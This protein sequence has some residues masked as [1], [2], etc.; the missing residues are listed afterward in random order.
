MHPCSKYGSHAP[1]SAEA[2]TQASERSSDDADKAGSEE[3]AK[4][5]SA[6]DQSLLDAVKGVGEA[7]DFGG[8]KK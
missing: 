3:Q 2:T 1:A 8:G 4:S 7:M 5:H 6:E